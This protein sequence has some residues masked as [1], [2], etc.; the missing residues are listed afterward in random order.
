[1]LH[2]YRLLQVVAALMATAAVLKLGLEFHRLVWD[3]GQTGAVDLKHVN[4]WVASW[5]AGL[6]VLT[7]LIK[8]APFP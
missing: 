5:F 4:R 8:Y 6:P 7:Y 1:M 3:S 2:R